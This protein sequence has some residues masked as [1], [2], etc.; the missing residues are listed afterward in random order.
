MCPF[1]MYSAKGIY[2]CIIRVKNKAEQ[3]VLS[4]API[5]QGQGYNACT[6]TRLKAQKE[7][8]QNKFEF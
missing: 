4:V 6:K 2:L 5:I 8:V 7:G 3:E 1:D